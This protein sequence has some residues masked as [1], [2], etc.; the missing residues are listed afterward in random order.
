MV[1]MTIDL[2]LAVATPISRTVR[3]DS[4]DQEEFVEDVVPRIPVATA[5]YAAPGFSETARIVLAYRLKREIPFRTM[6]C[7]GEYYYLTP[8]TPGADCAPNNPTSLSA[9]PQ[10]KLQLLH[11]SNAS[12]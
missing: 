11:V 7:E 9:S 3:E 4:N 2:T 5:V 6:T 8:A 10:R 12:H 1:I